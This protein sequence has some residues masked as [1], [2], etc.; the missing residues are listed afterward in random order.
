MNVDHVSVGSVNNFQELT[1]KLLCQQ[2]AR[3]NNNSGGAVVD[4]IVTTLSIK[5]H[6]E[7]FTT[8]SRHNNLTLFICKHTIKD[9]LLMLTKRNSHSGWFDT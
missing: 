6:G 4:N 9:A 1:A 2:N 3:S 5:N 7:S 8:T